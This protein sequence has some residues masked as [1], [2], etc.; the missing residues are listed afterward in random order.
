MTPLTRT[1]LAFA[2]FGAGL[3]HLAIAAGSALPLAI[4]LAGLG[5]AELGWG[6]AILHLGRVIAP[7]TVVVVSLMPVLV[8]GGS[9]AIMPGFGMPSAS[10]PAFPLAVASLFNLFIAV[11]VAIRLRGVAALPEAA[12]R[13]HQVGRFLIGLVAAGILVSGLTTP[14][15][16]ATEV[17]SHAVPHGTHHEP[18]SNMPTD[19]GHSH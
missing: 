2:A 1:W 13:T 15:L 16:A 6:V 4:P 14:A 18:G 11:L 7:R 12:P 3:I 9:A 19:N 8:W 5:A 10:L 17:G